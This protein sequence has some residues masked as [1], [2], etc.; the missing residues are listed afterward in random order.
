MSLLRLTYL[1]QHLLKNGRLERRKNPRGKSFHC[2]DSVYD[3]LAS[4]ALITRNKTYLR[5]WKE[6]IVR[7]HSIMIWSKPQDCSNLVKA[8]TGLF[9]LIWL[10][11][12]SV[13]TTL[14]VIGL[15]VTFADYAAPL[16]FRDFFDSSRWGPKEE[17]VYEAV[18]EEI[19]TAI[20]LM[21]TLWNQWREMKETRPKMYS[22]ILLTSLLMLAYIGNTINNLLLLYVLTM[23][24]VLLPGLKHHGILQQMI[25]QSIEVIKGI[26]S[27]IGNKPKNQ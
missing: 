7:L 19:A 12:T 20:F 3:N 18:C 10:C 21:N 16:I 15:V 26:S 17:K 27:K 22:F 11:N 9:V 14:S 6:I 25:N 2:T 1:L 24:I 13:L 8:V 5:G 23:S 4:Q